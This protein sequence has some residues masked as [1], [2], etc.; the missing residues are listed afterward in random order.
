MNNIDEKRYWNG[1]SDELRKMCLS[2]MHGNTSRFNTYSIVKYL[3]KHMYDCDY[4]ILGCSIDDVIHNIDVAI[5]SC[6]FPIELHEKDWMELTEDIEMILCRSEE[7]LQRIAPKDYNKGFLTPEDSVSVTYYVEFS[8]KLN[9]YYSVLYMFKEEW[10]LFRKRLNMLLINTEQ[11][12]S[13]LLS[14]EE[15]EK[16]ASED[17]WAE[18][19]YLGIDKWQPLKWLGRE[20][21]HSGIAR[22][23]YAQIFE[24]YVIYLFNIKRSMLV[25][26]AWLHLYAKAEIQLREICESILEEIDDY[27]ND[28]DNSSQSFSAE[29]EQYERMMRDSEEREYIIAEESYSQAALKKPAKNR[30]YHSKY[31]DFTKKLRDLMDDNPGLPVVPYLQKNIQNNDYDCAIAYIHDPALGD[32]ME[33]IIAITN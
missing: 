28:S 19:H 2:Q 7:L 9:V 13:Q 32:F 11:N 20:Y 3:I 25:N 18:Y 23:N 16:Y 12:V 17:D 29:A 5:E 24:C 15:A 26:K 30:I 1:V 6:L 4:I 8:Q 31:R 14:L 21:L 10:Q 22:R 27:L 33:K